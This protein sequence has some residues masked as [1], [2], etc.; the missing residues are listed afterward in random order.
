M[1][2]RWSDKCM[3]LTDRTVIKRCLEE[4]VCANVNWDHLPPLLL[5]AVFSLLFCH[6]WP[7]SVISLREIADAMRACLVS[8]MFR[9]LYWTALTWLK[10]RPSLVN[11][12]VFLGLLSRS[13]LCHKGACG[14]L[15]VLCFVAA[16]PLIPPACAHS[17]AHWWYKQNHFLYKP[18]QT[19][20]EAS[21][22]CSKAH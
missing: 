3:T 17:A 15:V 20:T 16:Q 22:V 1:L 7:F 8:H 13:S 10:W 14:F 19:A 21:V 12:L 4:V 9:C 2:W 6:G 5:H 11:R 18:L